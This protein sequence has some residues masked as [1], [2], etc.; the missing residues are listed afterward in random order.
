[1]FAE[2]C[3]FDGVQADWRKTI[4][5]PAESKIESLNQRLSALAAKLADPAYDPVRKKA[6]SLYQL[7][8][9]PREIFARLCPDLCPT[10]SE[11]CCGRVSHRGVLDEADLIFLAT[12]GIQALT[13]AVRS[14]DLCPWL[15]QEGC[16]LPWNARPFACLHYVC[17]PLRE[18]MGPNDLDDVQICLAQAGGLRSNLLKLFMEPTR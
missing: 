4:S 17:E 12:Q 18:A 13:R 6:D 5:T 9:V 11:A 14:D 8:G 2:Q 7:L 16:A 10:C 15:D 3:I 1:M